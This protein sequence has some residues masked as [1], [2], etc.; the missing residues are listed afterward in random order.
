MSRL[1]D[2][3]H[4]GFDCLPRHL[5][6]RI[7]HSKGWT[8]EALM[9]EYDVTRKTVLVW[10]SPNGVENWRTSSARSRAKQ[11]VAA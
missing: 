9:D 8:M 4:P 7:Y 3:A 5:Q 1:L 11:R 6:A 2:P 10:L